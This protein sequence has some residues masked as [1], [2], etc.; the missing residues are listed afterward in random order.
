MDKELILE[1][2]GLTKYFFQG[3]RV[4]KALDG[5]DIFIKKGLTTG[6]VGESGCGKTTLAKTLIGLYRPNQ[7]TIF[8]EGK[9]I[10]DVSKNARFVRENI[11]IV[12]QNPYLSVDPRYT[13]FS[14]LYEALTVYR[15][16]TKDKAMPILEDVLREVELDK[17]MFLRFPHALS[18]GQLQRV[19]IARSLVNRPKLLLLDE[20]TSNLDASTTYKI[21]KL[22][23]TLQKELSLSY[24]FISHN[25]KLVKHISHYIFVMYSGRIVE[26]GKSDSI[27]NNP[28]HPYTQLLLKASSYQLKDLSRPLAEGLK[29]QGGDE[30]R[31]SKGRGLSGYSDQIGE[32]CVFGD[33]CPYKMER[34]KISPPAKKIDEDQ[35][36]YCY[37]K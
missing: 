35:E 1:A 28:L 13:M 25:L 24:L 5:V 33:R 34:C 27:Y 8:F 11:Q 10:T 26:W 18:G 14:T 32:G 20:P 12:F 22:L 29:P 6:L 4:I 17:S 2:K 16:V 23:T 37:L 31:P 15:R 21:I 9:D 19:C 3:R 36:V 30:L 7:G